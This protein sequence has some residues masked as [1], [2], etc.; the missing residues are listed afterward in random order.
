LDESNGHNGRLDGRVALITGAGRG[1]GAAEA[2]R[3]AQ[4]GAKVAVLDLS[5]ENCKETVQK[6]YQVGSEATAVGCDVSKVDQIEEA[7]TK[8]VSRFGRLDILINNAGVLRDNLLFKMSEADWDTVI[9][10]HLKGSFLCA[11]AAQKYMVQ[12]RY[13]KILMTSSISALGNRG[14]TNYSAAKAGLMGMVKTLAIELGPFNINVNA[15][16]PGWTETEM[17]KEAAERIGIT[18]E[19]MEEQ[20]SKNIPL[21]RFGQPED[22]ANAAAFLVSDEASYIT[23]QT[24]FVSGGPAGPA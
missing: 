1:I 11:R 21:R 4:D 15:I 16:A 12:Q 13:G 22:I 7:F 2:V 19:E 17:T 24:L 20:F 8:V 18:V 10:V 6:V 23:G 3:L 5:E 9:D 14:Q